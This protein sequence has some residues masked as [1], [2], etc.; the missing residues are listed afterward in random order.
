MLAK[1]EVT[2][3]HLALHRGTGITNVYN[4]IVYSIMLYML[5]VIIFACGYYIHQMHHAVQK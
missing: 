5:I 3:L 4:C 1:S 2:A